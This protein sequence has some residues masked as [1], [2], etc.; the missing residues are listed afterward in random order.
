MADASAVAAYTRSVLLARRRAEMR[1]HAVAVIGDVVVCGTS[2]GTLGLWLLDLKESREDL[3][4]RVVDCGSAVYALAWCESAG[5]LAVGCDGGA[6]VLDWQA[7][8]SFVRH[9]SSPVDWDAT[10]PLAITLAQPQRHVLRNGAVAPLSECNALAWDGGRL[11]GGSGDGTI[12]CWTLG[13]SPRLVA[14]FAAHPEMVLSL[15]WAPAARTLASAS[16]DGTVA[17][18]DGDSLELKTRIGPIAHIL[19][20]KGVIP[21]AAQLR[22]WVGGVVVDDSARWVACAGGLEAK[23]EAPVA[24]SPGGWVATFHAATGALVRGTKTTAP[25]RCVAADGSEL[26]VG[27][28]DSTL[29]AWPL[30]DPHARSNEPA[31]SVPLHARAAFSVFVSRPP[32]QTGENDDDDFGSSALIFAAGA[33]PLVDVCS[34]SNH[35]FSLKF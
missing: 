35:L 9:N 34:E 30:R 8:E 10:P 13:E 24:K 1:V 28:D 11:W 17:L 2:L 21:A 6:A 3:P 26:V 22:C 16:E 31:R 15:A 7:V 5:A 32:A 33:A 20:A 27:G 12:S 23:G 14:H 18:W 19:E 29:R 25:C 4:A